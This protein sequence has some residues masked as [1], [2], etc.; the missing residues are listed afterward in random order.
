M[1]NYADY[2]FYQN[3]F[4]GSLS[5]DL[6]SYYIVKAS[7]VISKNVNRKLTEDVINSLSEEEQY[8]I[9]SARQSTF[10]TKQN[11]QK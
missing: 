3:E 9:N 7:R 2:D 1:R 10:W 4:H 6:F 5:N 8:Y 11:K